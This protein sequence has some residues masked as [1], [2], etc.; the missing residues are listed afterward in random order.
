MERRLL[1]VFSLTLLVI[2]LSQPLLKKYFPQPEP[3][4]PQTQQ[5]Q[6][7][8]AQAPANGAAPIALAAAG[9]SK[10]KTAAPAV[11]VKQASSETD[12]VV[13]NDLYR[14]TFTNRGGRVKSWVLKEYQDDQKKPLE[15]VNGA[16]AEKFGYPLSLWTY[17]ESQRNK[18]NSALYV[19]PS[20]GHLTA[21]AQVS[22]EYAD[23]EVE[24][25]KTFHFDHNYV[26]RVETSV[27]S[28]GSPVTAFPMWPAGFG[29][30]TTPT[31]FASGRIEYQYN[32]TTER[33]EIKKV[34]SGNTLRVP[35]NWAGPVDQYFAAVFIP[36]DPQNSAVVTLRHSLD[37]P[38][39]PKHP[40][41]ILGAAVGSVVGPTVE[42]LYVGPKSLSVLEAVQVP[43]VTGARRTC[44]IW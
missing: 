19:T 10:G 31:A 43:T 16:A 2:V 27:V 11:P 20:E 15:L 17:D 39:D 36:D 13:E 5:Q 3:A 24:V 42:R 1:L 8:P 44:A 29:D 25:H 34:S 4:P 35:F 18:I 6:P 30:A 37:N 14:I 7:A 12:L 26:V 41:E 32:G 40:N 33:L 9:S 22:F 21:P 28:N 38:V 23:G